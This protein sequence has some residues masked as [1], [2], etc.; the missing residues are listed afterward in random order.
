MKSIQLVAMASVLVC[1][2]VL[3]AQAPPTAAKD[4]EM[5]DG[6]EKARLQMKAFNMPKGMKAELY[7]AEPMLLSPVAI[8]LDEKNRVFVA[9]VHRLG[10]GAAENRDNPAFKFTFFLDDDLQSQTTADRLK[11]YEKHKA[12]LDGGMDWYTKYSDQVRLLEDTTGSGRA[13][14]SSVFA[15]GFNRAL[16]GLCAG[17]L[18]MNG[19]V[20][21]TNIPSLWKFKEGADGTAAKREE[22]LTGFGVNVAFFGHDMHGLIVG[23]DGRL[24]FSIGDRGFNVT[25][26]EGKQLVGPRMGGV[27]RCDFDGK[28]LELVHRGLRNPQELAFD[29]FGNLF[30]DDNNCDKGDHAR[31]VYVC[32]GG[33]SGW[34]MAYQSIPEPYLVGPWHAERMW[35]TYHAG[36][37]AWIT[38]CVGEIGTGP[39][40]FL[41]TSGTSLADRYK[42]S[43]LMCNFTGNGGL[44]SWKLKPQGAGFEM[45]DYHDFLKPI[46]A[47]DCEF[48]YDGKL[49]VSDYV[50]LNWNGSSAGG[51][52]YTVFDQEKINSDVVLGTKKLFEEGFNQRRPDELY[53]L[54]SHA[55]MRVRQRAQFALVEKGHIDELKKAAKVGDNLLARLHGIWGLGQLVK[56]NAYATAPLISMLFE[57][58]PEVRAQAAK[59]LGD[60]GASKAATDLVTLLADREPRVQFFAAQAL[61]QLGYKPALEALFGLAKSNGEADAY[62]RQAVVTALSRL[63]DADGVNAKANDPAASVRMAVVLVQRKL[64]D[65]R[66]SQF[67]KD[68]DISI[69]TEAARAVHDLNMEAEYPKLVAVLTDATSAS[70]DPLSRRAIHA[71][72]RLGGKEQAAA[73]LGVASDAKYSSLIRSEALTL[74]KIWGEAANRDRVTGHWRSLAKR[75]A[76]FVKALVQGNVDRLLA[77]TSGRLQLEAIGLMTT[78]GVNLDE[79]EFAKIAVDLKQ[80]VNLR[81]A[82]L[83]VLADR[84]SDRFDLAFN[85]ALLDDSPQLRAEARDIAANL[86]PKQA[87]PLLLKVLNDNKASAVERQ[88]AIATLAKLK[89]TEIEV[90]AN[91]LV[92]GQVPD[93]L[94]VDVWDVLK[95]SPN[96]K[97]Q[98][99]GKKYEDN[100]GR[101]P[102]KRFAIARTGGDAERGKELFMNHTAGQCIRCHAVN[103]AGGKAGPELA[104]VV[105]RN[106]DKTRDYLLESLVKPSAKIAPGYASITIIKLDGSSVAGLL[107]KAEKGNYEVKT[108][109]G[110]IVTIKADDID[111]ATEPVSGMP[112]MDKALTHR[113]MRDIIEY[114]MTLK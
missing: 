13:N 84:K 69:R 38:P 65:K 60:R 78:L 93:E 104:G 103:G 34:N 86:A 105:Q 57:Q 106:P 30:A 15:A 90:W 53:K 82:A 79:A 45:Y 94:R 88:R 114:L 109:D 95:T 33:D 63:G 101:D 20:F 68:S 56:T 77:K 37:P 22:L 72:Y 110:A 21:V 62:L 75:D 85:K 87:Q 17:V 11:M 89:D 112:T 73:V 59:T 76:G 61:G 8:S 35:N 43:F 55:D 36:Q 3:L 96:T 2:A 107:M 97:W 91:K 18:A 81:G 108:P 47:T 100:L 46:M 32:D 92:A 83:R 1:G 27:F 12:K 71:C 19:D 74:L 10:R 52:I 70:A 113:E 48:G 102:I 9:E 16:D 40:G 66:V 67:L 7:A 50:G 23:P 44:E 29:Q 54:L 98:E 58:E 80:D 51:R 41:F 99:L 14:K 64:S 26:K 42:N 5:P 25:S 4:P 24:Y 39:S 6:T 31:L 111:K 28:N 49:Y